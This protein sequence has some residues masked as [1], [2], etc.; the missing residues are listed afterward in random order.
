MK[1]RISSHGLNIRPSTSNV[2]IFHPL[3]LHNWSKFHV[4]FSL[5]FA[6]CVLNKV[7][8]GHRREYIVRASPTACCPVPKSVEP[9]RIEFA[10]ASKTQMSYSLH[11]S[12]DTCPTRNFVSASRTHFRIH[13]HF[14]KI[15]VPVHQVG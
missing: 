14:N 8:S 1:T 12:P 13:F 6:L 7:R 3:P 4:M 9:L 5:S 2:N 15:L 11:S 10:V